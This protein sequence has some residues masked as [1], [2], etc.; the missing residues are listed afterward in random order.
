MDLHGRT[1]LYRPVASFYCLASEQSNRCVPTEELDSEE[2]KQLT[3]R[4]HHNNS[5]NQ[6]QLCRRDYADLLCPKLH[7]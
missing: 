6:H 7:D 5:S 2:F 1:N 4:H 3:P